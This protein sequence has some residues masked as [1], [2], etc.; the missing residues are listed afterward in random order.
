MGVLE[1]TETDRALDLKMFWWL[2]DK[3]ALIAILKLG[4]A[5]CF[6]PFWVGYCA[7]FGHDQSAPHPSIGR[8]VACETSCL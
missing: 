7:R 2:T 1:D 8:G 4:S 3:D 5:G 6:K